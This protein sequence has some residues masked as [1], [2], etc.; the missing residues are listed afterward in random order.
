MKTIRTKVYQFNEL[1]EQAKEVAINWYRN[2]GNDGYI[3]ADEIIESVKKVAEL[4]NLKFGREYTD[5][6]T[7][8]IDDNILELKGIRLYKYIVNNYWSSL[9]KRK[10]LGCI[11]DNR[12]IKHR[13][14][15]THFYDMKKGARVNSSNFIYSNIQYDNSCTLTGVCYD[16]D[17]L[18]PVYDFLEKPNTSTTFED[19][20]NEIE[21]AISKTFQQNED[22]VNSDEYITEQIEANEYDFTKDGNRFNQ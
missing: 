2:D 16:M 8:H 18:Q 3:Y 9:F 1:T 14:S 15:K 10:Y 22:W 11:G 7:S 20:M 19:L 6:R 4:F 5:V 12:V 17:I 21:S 13:M